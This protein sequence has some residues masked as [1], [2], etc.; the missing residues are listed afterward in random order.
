MSKPRF[1]KLFSPDEANGLIPRLEI[2]VRD[3]QMMANYVRVRVNE[4]AIDN[5]ELLNRTLPEIIERH[6][7][8]DAPSTR[9]AEAIE[10]IEELGCFL[11]DIDQGLIDFPFDNGDEVVF[12]CWQFGEQSV[13]AWHPI[14]D[15]FAGRRPLPGAPK[16]WL[17]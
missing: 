6:P 14:G 12:L 4:L 2:I 13:L 8:L 10:Q 17:N 16:Q 9:M 1:Q 7:D 5:P 15:G 11:T 3:L